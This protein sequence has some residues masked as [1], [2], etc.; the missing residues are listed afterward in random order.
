[1]RILLAILTGQL[2][3]CSLTYEDIREEQIMFH[4]YHRNYDDMDIPYATLS[5]LCDPSILSL[6]P[7]RPWTNKFNKSISSPKKHFY[8]GSTP[9]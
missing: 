3:T 8:Y 5:D 9:Y 2:L 7:Y 4:N 1:M 6:V